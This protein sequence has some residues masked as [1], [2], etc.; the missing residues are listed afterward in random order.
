MWL[1]GKVRDV[2][3]SRM[4]SGEYDKFAR[5]GRSWQVVLVAVAVAAAV[6]V[7]GLAPCDSLPGE[8]REGFLHHAG[9]LMLTAN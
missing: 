1:A 9:K 2:F 6:A 4:M 3:S 7:A 5:C 8:G